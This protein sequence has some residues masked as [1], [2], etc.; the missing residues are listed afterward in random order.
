MKKTCVAGLWSA[1]VL[2]NV[3][4]AQNSVTPYGLIDEGFDFT[5]NA[6]RHRLRGYRDIEHTYSRIAQR[7]A[8]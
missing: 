8:L 4:H 5:T 6:A 2:C 1:L 3:A 7:R